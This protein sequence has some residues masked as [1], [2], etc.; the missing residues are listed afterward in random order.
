MRRQ[1]MHTMAAPRARRVGTPRRPYA[2]RVPAEVRRE[3]LLDAALRLAVDEG[4][5][6]LTMEAV[7]RQA[8]VTKPVVYELF[9]QRGA[10]Y[11]ALLDREEAR[12]L[13]QLSTVVP[14][15]LGTLEAGDLIGA[16]IRSLVTAVHDNPE[17]W[18]VLL[19]TPDGMPDEV[20]DRYT[21]RRRELVATIRVLVAAGR[22]AGFRLA[23][24]D[25]ELIAES[26]V[27]LGELAGR[28]A[29]REPDQFTAD[30][31]GDFFTDLAAGMLPARATTDTERTTGA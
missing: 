10:L 9:P 3:Q 25:D 29:L 1:V 28:L 14:P 17:M 6:A 7:A 8:G 26:L 20:R 21:Q 5:T 18:T 12:A 15:G 11:E 30:R 27:A 31:L 22:A 13:A 4:I 2:A 24:T 23:S 19:R 16:S